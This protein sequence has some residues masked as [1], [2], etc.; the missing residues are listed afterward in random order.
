[1]NFLWERIH[2]P[3]TKSVFHTLGSAFGG[4]FRM[5][6][7]MHR[8]AVTEGY[9]QPEIALMEHFPSQ[10]KRAVALQLLVGAQFFFV[11]HS[12]I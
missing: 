10:Q 8:R 12:T 3:R 4:L 1:M 6:T 2:R 9:D 5:S 11:S 7:R